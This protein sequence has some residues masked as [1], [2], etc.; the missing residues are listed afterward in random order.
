LGLVGHL[1][2]LLTIRAETILFLAPLQARAVVVVVAG[3]PLRLADLAAADLEP[4]QTTLDQMERLGR[5]TQ[6]GTARTETRISQPG[7][8]VALVQ[9]AQHRQLH[10]QMAEMEVAELL[11]LLVVLLLLMPE[12]GVAG[13]QLLPELDKA[14]AVMADLQAP[15]TPLREPQILAAVA[16]VAEQARTALMA[17]LALSSFAIQVLIL[18]PLRPQVRQQ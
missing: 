15:Q 4:R 6:A 8:A 16:A 18:R 11:V 17:A 3:W 1:P 10:L 12:A 7:A 5:V 13:P 14:A 2:A 9:Q